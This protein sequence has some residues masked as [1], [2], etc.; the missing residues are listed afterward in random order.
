MLKE[1]V[2]GLQIILKNEPDSYVAAEHD[3]VYAGELEDVSS[4]PPEDLKRLE[5]LGFDR[6]D[7][8]SWCRYV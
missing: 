8:N 5:E 3:E 4:Y 6:S 2:E 1:L 7:F